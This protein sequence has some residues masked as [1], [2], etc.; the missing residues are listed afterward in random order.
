MLGG[1]VGNAAWLAI[2]A[3]QEA[4]GL[5]LLIG[6]GFSVGGAFFVSRSIRANTEMQR[7]RQLEALA[8]RLEPVLLG[9]EREQ[10]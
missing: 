8:D 4:Y 5:A 9:R 2:G 3:P 6:L 1:L 7:R 10:A